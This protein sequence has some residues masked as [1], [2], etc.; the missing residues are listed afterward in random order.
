[1]R[2]G[3][4]VV[5]GASSGIGYQLARCCAADGYDLV[6]AADQADVGAVAEELREEGRFVTAVAG[7]LAMPSG[8]DAVVEAVQGRPVEV[9]IANAGHGL[10]QAFLDQHFDEVQHVIDT[11]ITGTLD[12]VQRIG[13]SMRE[14]GRG[15]ILITGSVAG[16]IPGSYQAV[17]NASQAFIVSFSIA[18]RN[19]LHESGVSVTCLM[20]GP[21]DTD[22]FDRAGLTDTRVASAKKDDPAYVAREGYRAMQQGQGQVVTG[23][24]NKLHVAAAHVTPAEMLAEQHRRQTEPGPTHR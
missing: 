21:T 2:K 20:P 18:L 23:L 5:T 12:L 9:L 11:N 10:G 24:R 6:L 14:R 19:E 3:L 22:F 16:F 15:K 1:M 7:D 17:Y 13:Q 4:A 8:V